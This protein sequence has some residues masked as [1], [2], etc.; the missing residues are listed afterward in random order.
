MPSDESPQY[1]VIN[2][3]ILRK[4]NPHTLQQIEEEIEETTTYVTQSDLDGDATDATTKD[5]PELESTVITT[6][7]TTKTTKRLRA[8][9]AA[10]TFSSSLSKYPSLGSVEYILADLVNVA[11]KENGEDPSA[12]VTTKTIDVD[13]YLSQSGK[14]DADTWQDNWLF[15]KTKYVFMPISLM[16][17]FI[18]HVFLQV[19]EHF[20]PL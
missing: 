12:F 6:K 15:S 18:C 3:L 5:V 1:L 16:T 11:A 14:N 13:D 7:K 17:F 19:F 4:F 10:K 20:E 9:P 8:P 2:Q